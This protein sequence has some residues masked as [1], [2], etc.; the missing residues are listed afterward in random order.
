MPQVLTIDEGLVQRLLA[1]QFPAWAELPVQRVS[2]GGWDNRTFRLGADLSVRLPSAER[3]AAQ[4]DREQQWLPQLAPL[5]PCAIPLPAARG[6]P[7]C[8]YPF[9]WSIYRWIDGEPLAAAG[10]WRSTE[11]ARELAGFLQALHACPAQSGPR[12]GPQNFHRGGDLAVYDEEMQAALKR[13]DGELQRALRQVWRDALASEHSDPAVW[14]HGDF[15]PRN[16]LVRGDR[17]AGVI[18]FGQVA[19]GDPACDLAI[20]WTYLRGAARSVFRDTVGADAAAWAR[21][22]GWVAWKAAILQSGVADGPKADVDAAAVTIQ[23]LL[24]DL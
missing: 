5:L 17:L 8:G 12:P 6:R 2:P 15:A 20:T 24:Q 14:V 1:D 23:A 18:D 4:V 11:L 10:L 19:A 7:G 3:Y 13:L 21:A 16:L 9:D 22:R